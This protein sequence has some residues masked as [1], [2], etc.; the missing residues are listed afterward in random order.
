MNTLAL[1]LCTAIASEAA[2]P[3]SPK[4]AQTFNQLVQNLPLEAVNSLKRD[5]P[6]EKPANAWLQKN[7][8]GQVVTFR[9]KFGEAT[10]F[11]K[12][13]GA[14][15]V[16][17]PTEK[18]PELKIHGMTFQILLRNEVERDEKVADFLR[19]GS[20]FWFFPPDRAAAER[21]MK[22]S[23]KEATVTGRVSRGAV[24]PVS[25]ATILDVHLDMLTIR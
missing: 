8:V 5:F 12:E 10:T 14:L 23:E 11:T 19:F 15:L 9:L 25:H 7:V 24:M 13:D 16:V 18:E 21:F 22:L 2:A 4:S 1:L 20:T 3:P 6:D 17:L